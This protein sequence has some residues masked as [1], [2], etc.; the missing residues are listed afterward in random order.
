MR[1]M[2]NTYL[3]VCSN[4]FASEKKC[5][6]PSKDCRKSTKTS[7]ATCT[8]DHKSFKTRIVV[9]SVKTNVESVNWSHNWKYVSGVSYASIVSTNLTS[10]VDKKSKKSSTT[11]IRGKKNA[12]RHWLEI[13]L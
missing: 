10:I 1:Q 4:C 8:T 3:H 13:K 7:R 6:H 9:N 2:V 5:P 12:V 11:L